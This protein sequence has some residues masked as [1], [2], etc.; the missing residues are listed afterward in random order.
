MLLGVEC[1]VSAGLGLSSTC[2]EPQMIRLSPRAKGAARGSQQGRQ[3]RQRAQ[4]K[5]KKQ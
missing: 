2:L 5:V 1:E 4:S 3:Q